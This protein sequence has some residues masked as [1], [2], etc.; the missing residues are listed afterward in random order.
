MIGIISSKEENVLNR[1]AEE[2]DANK[3]S[4]DKFLEG[5]DLSKEECFYQN[6]DSGAAFKKLE[7]RKNKRRFLISLKNVASVAAIILPV[8]LFFIFK[9]N[10]KEEIFVVN[11]NKKCIIDEAIKNVPT[12]TTSTGRKI[13][14]D[15]TGE[16]SIKLHPDFTIKRKG[17]DLIIAKSTKSKIKV[18]QNT[19]DIPRG[20]IFHVYLPDGTSVWLNAKSKLKFPSA[21]TG[22]RRLVELEGEAFFDVA[23]DRIHP[24]IVKSGDHEIKVLGTKFNVSAYK[25]DTN[26]VTSLKSGKVEILSEGKLAGSLR[27]RQKAVYNKKTKKLRISTATIANVLSWLSG[28]WFFSGDNLG[29]IMKK[30]ERW[31]SVKFVVINKSVRETRIVGR[32]KKTRDLNEILDSIEKTT[33]VKFIRK[34]KKIVIVKMAP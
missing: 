31:Y 13:V 29:E 7:S 25:E 23:K 14:L 4:V 1:W 15:S 22:K 9:G 17:T 28:Y 27:P 3:R 32:F 20:S 19:L 34:N 16:E 6:L 10:I 12:I 11:K 18:I 24:F 21:F 26:I 33:N 8:V 5:I 2:N 30:L